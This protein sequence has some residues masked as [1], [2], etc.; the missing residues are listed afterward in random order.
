[1]P[2]SRFR[3]RSTGGTKD[4][5]ACRPNSAPAL[6]VRHVSLEEVVDGMLFLSLI[7]MLMWL[8]KALF[9]FQFSPTS[10]FQPDSSDESS[11]F[12]LRRPSRSCL[13]DDD[14]DGFMEELDDME[15]NFLFAFV[16]F[17]QFP[18]IFE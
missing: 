9:C 7:L 12:I 15:V 14:D 2:A 13:H 4:A 1:M 18:L 11:P 3:T 16:L 6:M 8:L 10:S 5:F 17:Q